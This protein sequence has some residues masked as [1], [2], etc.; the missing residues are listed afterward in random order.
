MSKM[1]KVLLI[2]TAYALVA[3][4][5]IGSTIAY[6]QDDDSDVNV[7]TL[8]DVR[9]DQIEQERDENGNLIDFTQAKPAYPAVG[10]VAWDDT[11]L[12][13]NGSEYQ[14]FDDELKNVVDKIVTVNNTGKSDAYIRTI[15]AIEAPDYD[16][17]DL[18]HINYNKDV[19]ISGPVCTEIDGVDYV[20][21][22]FTYE[23]ALGAGEKSA[24]SL[25]QVF[26]DS[27]ATNVDCAK[28][29]ESWEV[30]VKSQAVQAAGFEDA[31]TALNTALGEITAEDNPGK[32]TVLVKVDSQ[33]ELLA[34][35][36]EKV[37]VIVITDIVNVTG[38]EFN[39]DNAEVILA[40]VGEGSYAY[41]SFDPDGDVTVENLN[42]VGSGFVQIGG[43]NDST[44]GNYVVNNLTIKDITATPCVNESG[45]MISAAFSQYGTDKKHKLVCQLNDCVMTGTKMIDPAYTAYDAAFVN[46]TST[47]INGGEYGKI[48]LAP[49]AWVTIN[50]AE[51]DV[52][53]SHAISYSTLGKL[54]V[55]E[56]AKVGTIYLYDYNPSLKATLT[57][58]DGATVGTIVYN[59]TT[60]TQAEW[61]A[62]GK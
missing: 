53:D 32:K 16:P 29:G 4:V 40:G 39:G 10:D 52:I 51:V 31:T 1:K 34:G 60:Y 38:S 24:P 44:P 35:L 27:K 33:E 50:N 42:V 28:F 6:L 54:I 41:L 61:L 26:L 11:K 23:E 55:G 9:I 8:G 59:G 43:H 45:N 57:I 3:A 37:E 18:I 48:Y 62:R 56:G 46:S 49:Q 2:C 36:A 58:K 12:V 5:A 20:L 17:N 25:M 15:V 21:F 19:N 30:L 7:M 22:V 47:V 14:V 13:V